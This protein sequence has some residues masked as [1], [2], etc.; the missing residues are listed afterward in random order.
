MARGNRTLA[1]NTSFGLAGFF[2]VI[3]L[4]G[5]V[6]NPDFGTGANLSSRLF[7]IDWNGWHAVGTLFLGVTALVATARPLWA[8]AFLAANAAANATTATWALF[9]RSPLGVVYLPHVTTDVVLHL[10]VTAVSLLAFLAQVS[11][12][13]RQPSTS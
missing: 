3:G 2:L 13:R 1:Q 4:I 10:L 8:S 9:D 11:H 7:I 5:L 12:D 6:V